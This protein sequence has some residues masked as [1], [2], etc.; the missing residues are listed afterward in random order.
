MAAGK[1]VAPAAETRR[2]PSTDCEVPFIL[3]GLFGEA[4]AEAIDAAPDLELM[5]ID[6][7]D[8]AEGDDSWR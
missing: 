5:G 7:E 1:L 8:D 6:V 4:D 2:G 3:D